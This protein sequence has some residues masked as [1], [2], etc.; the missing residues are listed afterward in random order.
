MA[1]TSSTATLR[2]G[3]CLLVNLI[4]TAFALWAVFNALDRFSGMSSKYISLWSTATPSIWYSSKKF[5]CKVWN[6]RK[7]SKLKKKRGGS[8]WT[9]QPL[10][11]YSRY[12]APST[13]CRN[14]CVRMETHCF[15]GEAISFRS[16]P[17]TS[18]YTAEGR[19]V[20]YCFQ[21][22]AG[23]HTWNP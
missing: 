15:R 18:K 9:P 17:S 13:T 12:P 8:S 19:V 2:Q 10:V 22:W 6:L 14:Q 21:F 4:F 23:Q 1:L 3:E 16:S 11:G 20:L 7:Q 5:P